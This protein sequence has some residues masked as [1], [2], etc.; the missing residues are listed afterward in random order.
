MQI[1]GSEF[2]GEIE[3]MGKNVKQFK[4]GDP[5]FG[6]PGQRMGAYATYLCMPE[7]GCVAIKPAGLSYEEAA[8]LPYGAV[9]ALNL[10]RKMNIRPGQKVLING[11]SGG[12]GSAAVQIAKHHFKAEVTGVCGSPRLEFVKALGAD[13]VIDYTKEDFTSNGDTYDLVFDILGRSSFSQ[14]KGSLKPNGRYLLASFKM[15]QLLQMLW[16]RRAG[17]RVICAIAPGSREDL[18]TVLE[19][20]EA[21]KIKPVI[22][23]IFPMEQAAEA[24][25]YLEEGNARGKIAIT[26]N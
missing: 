15:R 22:D 8:V 12:I 23:K 2:A 25:K 24:H 26:I 5:V 18:N 3:S 1:L 20:I 6:F 16:T 14:C 17:K 19:L 4:K 13:K 7:N 21:G 9:M 11:A 10:L